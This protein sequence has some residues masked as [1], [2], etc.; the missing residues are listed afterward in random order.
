MLLILASVTCGRAALRD[1]VCALGVCLH[2]PCPEPA[3]WEGEKGK[4]ERQRQTKPIALA[5]E[6]LRLARVERDG[7]SF[8]PICTWFCSEQTQVVC[9]QFKLWH[10]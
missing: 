4:V 1:R 7:F 10:W 5:S 3:V 9:S 6:D 8:A 2:L